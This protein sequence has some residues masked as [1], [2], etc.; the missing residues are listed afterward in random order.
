MG[1]IQ[2]Q[3]TRI[4]WT[5]QCFRKEFMFIFLG[6]LYPY[7]SII[8]RSGEGSV[9]FPKD[10][11]ECPFNYVYEGRQYVQSAVRITE[12]HHRPVPLK[13]SRHHMTCL[14]LHI[15]APVSGSHTAGSVP[16]LLQ[17]Q[18]THSGNW[19]KPGTHRSHCCPVTLGLHLLRDKGK[20]VPHHCSAH[21][22][23]RLPVW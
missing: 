14:T 3:I 22:S 9:A 4:P 18:G 11:R 21:S 20:T 12:T 10:E 8:T 17:V 13:N 23:K 15:Q 5:S 16:S 19:W 6:R 7:Q 2:D 1:F